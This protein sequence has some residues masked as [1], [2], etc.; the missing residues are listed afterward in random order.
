MRTFNTYFSDKETLERFIKSHH[1]DEEKSILVQVF[2]GETSEEFITRMRDDIIA[3]LPQAR[4]IGTTT[5]GEICDGEV[6]TRKAV[7]S[8]SCFEETSVETV[9]VG[10]TRKSSRQS[11]QRLAEGLLRDDA[12]VFILFSDGLN[13]N[14]EAFL[15]GVESVAP[16]IVVAGG[17][18]GDNAE[19]VMTRV[20]TEKEIYDN[21]AVGAVLC[22]KALQVHND[23]SFN[24][25]SIG[26]SMKVTKAK[27][28][29]VYTIENRSALD[30]YRY[31]L[32]DEIARGLPAVGIEFPLIIQKEGLRVARAVVGKRP[33]GSLL[34]AGNI[35]EGD[36]VWFGFGNIET[37][38]HDSVKIT[39]TLS[40]K[41]VESIFVYS[42]MAR[43]RF[44][45]ENIDFELK[46]IAHTGKMSGFFTYGEFYKNS[47]SELLNQTMTLL[48]LSE[49][50]EVQKRVYV[51][52]KDISTETIKTLSA[53][54]H[55]IDVTSL[56]LLESNTALESKAKRLQELNRELNEN[57][58]KLKIQEQTTRA[59]LD[60]SPS[61]II[62]MRDDEILDV[63][64][65]FFNFFDTFPTLDAFKKQYECICETFF[66]Y[67][68][69][70][71]LYK[72][73]LGGKH[74][75]AYSLQYAK[76]T[77]KVAISKE[78]GLEH[79][80]IRLKEAGLENEHL[81]V[82]ELANITN[83][84]DMQAELR[85]KDTL[86]AHQNKL[87][88][89]G[90]F[91]G[92]IAHQWR[93]PLNILGLGLSNLDLKQRMGALEPDELN[94]TIEHSLEQIAFMSQTIDDFRN[95]FKQD[96]QVEKVAVADLIDDVRKLS[97]AVFNAQGIEWLVDAPAEL[98]V[99]AYPNELKQ[100][101]LNIV[102]NARD[103]IEAHKPQQRQILI[104]A[105][106]DEAY[107]TIEIEDTGGG[108]D[109]KIIDRIFEPYFTT[110]FEA[111]GTGIG[112]YM[113]KSIIETN[114]KGTIGVSNTKRGACFKIR[115][116]RHMA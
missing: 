101:L 55:L 11:G 5:D 113:V 84:V 116:P 41:P 17:L 62:L 65:E 4:V 59:I 54:S 105:T 18:A 112:L 48:A 115:L 68:K 45:R 74:W 52:H 79:F 32:G 98:N 9:G 50:A 82:V 60:S 37:I 15:T 33:D 93:Q 77:F 38:M 83:E 80:S 30:T 64:A 108:I 104:R 14:G 110:K 12:R 27:A 19:F 35:S 22:G 87:A 51:P 6:S 20:F 25:Q 57:N 29:R 56:E 34:F 63:N 95:F 53:L 75:V 107:C 97:E 88:A 111:Q 47:R 94:N 13:T 89:M 81:I 76:K 66:P 49:S 70:G 44:L 7:V 73:M 91:I 99:E 100:A 1:L 21:G 43:R 31:Y 36:E 85:E 96:K 61:I 71:Y 10:I 16:D 58:E 26:K 78:G 90:E 114:H 8:I 23:F 69:E 46:S 72:A 106:G 42:C 67:P 86:L 102:Y 92:S 2:S 40:R 28:N 24:W 103:A 109:K 39:D 3:L